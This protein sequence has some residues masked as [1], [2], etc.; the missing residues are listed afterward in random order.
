[1]RPHCKEYASVQQWGHS[2]TKKV[3]KIWGLI[4]G[5][6]PSFWGIVFSDKGVSIKN[7]QRDRKNKNRHKQLI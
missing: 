7:Q 5:L 1:M 2:I 6:S 4:I 3:A